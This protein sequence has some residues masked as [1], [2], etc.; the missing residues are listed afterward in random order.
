M[1]KEEESY[2][3]Q[4]RSKK[5]TRELRHDHD[6]EGCLISSIQI[7]RFWEDNLLNEMKKHKNQELLLV[8]SAQ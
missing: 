1:L 2:N 3:L 4:L 6:E 7:I 8:Q 5:N